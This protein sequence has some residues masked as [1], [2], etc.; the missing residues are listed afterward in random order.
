MPATVKL[1]KPLKTHKGDVMELELRDL[2]A[3]D[4][5]EMRV[6]PLNLISSRTGIGAQSTN[7]SRFEVRYDI[8]MGYV[9]RLSGIDTILLGTLPLKDFDACVA[10][11]NKLWNEAGE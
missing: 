9:S 10:A 8:A 4:A 5:V 1:S 3:A 6:P 2:T 7:E 11:V